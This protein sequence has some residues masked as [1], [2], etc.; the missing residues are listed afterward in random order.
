MRKYT[1]LPKPLISYLHCPF[2]SNWRHL[3]TFKSLN[4][5]TGRNRF[6]AITP[7]T[8]LGGRLSLKLPTYLSSRNVWTLLFESLSTTRSSLCQTF[9]WKVSF[10]VILPGLSSQ[11]WQEFSSIPLRKYPVWRKYFFFVVICPAGGGGIVGDTV[12]GSM[13]TTRELKIWIDKIRF[14]KHIITP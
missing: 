4:K 3:S 14:L 5:A 8:S 10:K 6:K 2:R 11:P 1:S 13:L 7:P 9:S 12:V